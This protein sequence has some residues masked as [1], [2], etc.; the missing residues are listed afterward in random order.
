[1]ALLIKMMIAQLLLVV[2]I[3]KVALI[4]TAMA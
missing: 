2:P 4:K 3:Q 1:M